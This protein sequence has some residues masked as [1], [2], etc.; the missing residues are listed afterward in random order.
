MLSRSIEDNLIVYP[1]PTSGEI[2]ISEKV[3]VRVYNALGEAVILEDGVSVLDVSYL[4]PGVYMMQIIHNNKSFIK[5][6]V[7]E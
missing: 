1:N 2:N 3:D 4:N 7:K 6:I 5:Q